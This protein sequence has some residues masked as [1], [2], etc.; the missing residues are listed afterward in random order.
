M[1][2]Q[3]AQSR[4]ETLEIASSRAVLAGKPNRLQAVGRFPV[5]FKSMAH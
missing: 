5:D 3:A 4:T 2:E 1:A